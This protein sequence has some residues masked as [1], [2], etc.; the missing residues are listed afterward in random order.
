MKNKLK[1]IFLG[2]LLSVCSVAMF[3][4]GGGIE[5][6]PY[7]QLD[8]IMSDMSAHDMFTT[9]YV[10][11]VSSKY[12]LKAFTNSEEK[13][14]SECLII[15]MNFIYKYQSDLS[16]IKE[17][18]NLTGEQSNS[19]QNLERGITEIN[20]GFNKLKNEYDR[21]ITFQTAGSIYEGVKQAFLYEITDFI[22]NAYDLAFNL[23]E[24]ENKVFYRYEDKEVTTEVLTTKDTEYFKDYLS[25][26]IGQDYYKLLL[27][28]VKSINYPSTSEL[29][30]FLR[31]VKGRLASFI[32][33]FVGGSQFAD[34]T[35][36]MSVKEENG[37]DVI[38]YTNDK[39][40]SLYEIKGKLDTERGVL[41]ESLKAFSLYD[42]IEIYNCDIASY[43]KV[44]MYAEIY[45]NQIQSY[46]LDT[47]SSYTTYLKTI[48]FRS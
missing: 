26:S 38:T 12:V 2:L 7:T 47:L 17:M 9:S 5:R 48:L 36:E 43:K 32:T 3:A 4:C 31:N 15:P 30:D 14:V 40:K 45:Y 42:Y 22:Q 35:G 37:K 46:Y 16:I 8:K 21:F 24:V 19:I 1:K 28:S 11:S 6:T 44:N 23:A 20:V 34:L 41:E 29:G 33:S 18:K 13:Y 39:M 27:P 10:D 25:L